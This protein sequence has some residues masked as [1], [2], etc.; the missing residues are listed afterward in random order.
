MGGIAATQ[1][2]ERPN[3]LLIMVDD[4]RPELACY[5]DTPARTPHIDALARSGTL[6]RRAY[7]QQALCAPSRAS[8]LT[9]LRPDSLGVMD[10]SHPV[11]QTRPD[12]RTL[13]QHFRAAGYTTLALGKIYHHA[14]DDNGVGWSSPAWE[15]PNAW[16][17]A[18]DADNAARGKERST[19]WEAAD[20]ADDAYPDGQIAARAAA[21]LRRFKA[22]GA[23]FFLAV[24]F[25]KPHLPFFAPKRYWDLYD[26]SSF[27]LPAQ[28]TW[29]TG[30]PHIASMD[31]EE[32]RQYRGIPKSGPLDD[33][34]ARQ[35]IHGYYACVSYVDAMV[36]QVLA[37]LG[38]TGL[39]ENTVVALL[40][41]HGWKLDDYGAWCKHTNFEIDTRAP[42]IVSAPQQRQTGVSDALVEFVDV[43][44]SLAQLA[45]LS[46][47]AEC[48]GTSF[49]PLL[50]DPAQPWKTAAFSLYPRGQHV[51]GYTVRDARWRYTEW[52]DRRTGNVTARELYDHAA[53]PVAPT[54]LANAPAHAA[55][56]ER[57]A[58]LLDHGAGWRQVRAAISGRE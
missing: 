9:G 8:L 30:M 42:L 38:R 26:R 53:S 28:R 40:G 3:V 14:K 37:E 17:Q 29:P 21:E 20:V 34:L 12:V 5:G 36:G 22:S 23:P 52:I 19:A 41:D 47:P 51:I 25:L 24:G 15:P 39:R 58:R 45:G 44:P 6:F 46:V 7:C 48:E 13:P 33:E 11:R 50:R 18:I 27:T 43:F 16:N 55:E 10:L 54:N 4:L 2:S 31:S 56:V 32:L 57:L 35:L 49:V 1:G